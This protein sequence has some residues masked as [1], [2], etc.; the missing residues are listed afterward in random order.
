MAQG[1]LARGK[2][3]LRSIWLELWPAALWADWN[4]VYASLVVVSR[5]MAMAGSYMPCPAWLHFPL[6]GS[7]LVS[8]AGEGS[9]GSE[10]STK[11]HRIPQI[12]G[13]CGAGV[14]RLWTGR[15]GLASAGAVGYG[16]RSY[17]LQ[18]GTV[19]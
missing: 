19:D 8:L 3:R 18:A 13:H 5:T 10:K 4:Q 16:R 14:T 11:G 15:H 2:G 17:Q 7:E 1:R 9:S 6:T 12:G